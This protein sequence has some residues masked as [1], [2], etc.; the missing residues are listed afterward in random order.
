VLRNSHPK[1]RGA[2]AAQSP[3]LLNEQ[4]GRAGARRSCAEATPRITYDYYDQSKPVPAD[5]ITANRCARLWRVSD[6]LGTITFQ[7][8]EAGRTTLTQRLPRRL[9]NF[10]T[11]RHTMR[12]AA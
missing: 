9:R 5:G 2:P 10:Q 8:D 11:H 7:Y 3:I 6:E 4:R 1:G 12:S